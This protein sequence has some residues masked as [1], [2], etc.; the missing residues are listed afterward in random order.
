MGGL[1]GRKGGPAGLRRAG[2]EMSDRNDRRRLR[3]QSPSSAG[4]SR[5]TST[6][7]QLYERPIQRGEAGGGNRFPRPAPQARAK[8]AASRA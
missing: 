2:P 3:H 8:E 5:T 6:P 1:E 4:L 7:G